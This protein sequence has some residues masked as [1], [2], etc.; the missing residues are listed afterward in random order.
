MRTST[1]IIR[2]FAVVPS[3]LAGIFIAIIGLGFLPG[4]GL[5]AAFV[6][7]LVV[8]IVLATGLWEFPAARVFGFAR[9]LRAGERANLA[10]TLALLE[11]LNLAPGRVLMRG[12]DTGGL[13]A[14]PIGRR[15]VIVEPNVIQGLYERRLTREDAA[16]AIGHAVASQ[17]VG[18]ARFDL[19][20]RLWAFPWTL[21]YV[22][23]RQITCAFS[24]VPAAGL[25]WHLR[26]VVG[27][28]VVV[29]GFQPGGDP[30]LGVA[31]G[32]L[33]AISYIAPAA[34]RRW[35]AVVERD[36]DRILALA[37]LV[38][39]MVHYAQW[40]LGPDSMERVQRIAAAAEERKQARA[41]AEAQEPPRETG[42][43]VL[44][45]P[46]ARR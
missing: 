31:T 39:S 2:L 8:S 6:G 41:Q 3:A 23:I 35:R 14:S 22:V 30:A 28:I 40:Q 12:T 4:A 42:G 25:A 10:P 43:L 15:T 24:W 36:A 7:T 32:V 1:K 17:R 37:G 44:A 9:G 34:D 20:A 16:A 45:H 29:Q 11:V 5:V 21:L 18:P 33:V 38:G 13:A 46:T 26:I 27:V 19:A